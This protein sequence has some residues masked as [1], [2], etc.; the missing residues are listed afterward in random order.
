VFAVGGLEVEFVVGGKRKARR[1]GERKLFA[2][3][4]RYPNLKLWYNGG[5][6]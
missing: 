4:Y 6:K 3:D 5:A 1:Y 2:V